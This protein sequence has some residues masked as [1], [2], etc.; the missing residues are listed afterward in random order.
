MTKFYLASSLPFQVGGY[1]GSH[2]IAHI[3]VLSITVP[4]HTCMFP[5]DDYVASIA[6]DHASLHMSLFLLM[7]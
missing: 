7:I 4:S 2:V 5:Y 1:I 3:V 6:F